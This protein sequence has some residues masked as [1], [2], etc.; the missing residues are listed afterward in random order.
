MLAEAALCYSGDIL[1]PGRPKYDLKYYVQLGRDLEKFGAN[2]LAIKDMAGVC[3]PHAA[4][5]LVKALKQEV[6]IPIHFHTHDC[7]GSQMAAILLAAQEDV[8][9]ADAA[10]APFSGMTSQVNLNT[11]VESLRFTPRGSELPFEP[12][13]QAAQYWEQVR[14]YYRPFESDQLPL[15]ADLYRHEMPGGQ[16]TNLRQ[17]AQA[18]GLGHRWHDICR[19]YAEVNRLF[20]D[21]IKVTPTSK[22]VGDMA[23][24]MVGNNLTAKEIEEGDRELAFPESV[25][26]LFEGRLG[27]PPGGFPK[28]LQKRVLRGRKPMRGRPGASLPAADF[29]ATRQELERKLRRQPDDR[30]V[31]A[32]LLYPRVFA[33]FAEHHRKYSDTSVLPTPVFFYGMTPGEE[34]SVDIEPGKT[35]IIKF[36]TVGDPHPD[37][38]RLVFFELNGQ[39]REVLVLDRSLSPEVRARPKAEPGNPKHVGSPMPGVIVSVT[40]AG[41]EEVAAGQKLFTLEAMKMETTV[42]ADRAGRV[43]EVMVAVGTQVEAGDLLLRL[44]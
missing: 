12:L 4:R 36:L 25:V 31:V 15:S 2:L 44:E 28:A 32:Y 41:G 5:L 20:G 42:Y 40:A 7:G 10:M 1:D 11:L 43:A 22:V 34:V 18:L 9:I 23:L 29:A 37:G 24:F 39:P 3:K 6:G 19:A 38:Q 14:R 8:D 27:Q 35:L 16:S 17:Q 33:D 21:I 30:E 26:E 13:E